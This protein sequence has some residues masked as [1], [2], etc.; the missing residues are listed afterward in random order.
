M[1]FAAECN[2]DGPTPGRQSLLLQLPV[3]FPVRV[4]MQGFTLILQVVFGTSIEM[5][6]SQKESL[7]QLELCAADV[8][9]QGSTKKLPMKHQMCVC[10]ATLRS[11]L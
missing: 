8:C 6:T 10:R 9:M 1:L 5:H 7:K 3:L 4:K 2:I 11:Y